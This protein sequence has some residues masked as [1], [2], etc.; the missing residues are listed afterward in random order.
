LNSWVNYHSHTNF[1]DGSEAPEIYLEEAVRLG[2]TAYGFSAH[3]PVPFQTNWCLPDNRF[4]DYL[5][6]IN[7]LKELY[8]SKIKVYLGLEIDYIPGI[9]GRRRHLNSQAALDYFIGS[10]HFVERFTDG[11]Y[12][13]IDTSPELFQR[14]L[15]EIF[16][17]DFRSAAT[18]FWE[19][20]R[21]M[22]E[23]DQPD[24]IGHLD[25]I[26]M[27][28]AG[29]Q[30]F[31]ESESW[32][33]EQVELTLKSIKKAGSIVEVNT[34]GYYRYNQPDLYPGERI[35]SRLAEEDIPVIISSD[36][37]KPEEIV[38]GMAHAALKLKNLGIKK[39]CLLNHSGWNQYSFSENGIDVPG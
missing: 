26:K 3:A 32:Y 22:V 33:R 1:C 37:H 4:Q 23:T 9:A 5:N 30:Y 8:K 17:S 16:G 25:K 12:W 18:R 19:L 10:V 28:N 39:L 21:Q 38:K 27:F 2:F 14:G 15:K 34:R 29:N 24:I 6:E 35:I 31:R 13:N 20:T 7:R 36:A 11:G